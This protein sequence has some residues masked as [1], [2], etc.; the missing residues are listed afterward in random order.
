MLCDVG[1]TGNKLLYL[2]EG[3]G[4]IFCNISKNTGRWDIC[5]S[6]AILLGYGGKLVDIY[7]NP[8]EYNDEGAD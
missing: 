6:E 5:A 4:H 8:Y 7:G 3:K 1:G 2:S